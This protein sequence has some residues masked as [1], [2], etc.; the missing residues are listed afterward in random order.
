MQVWDDRSGEVLLRPAPF[1][2]PGGGRAV[3]R[4]DDVVGASLERGAGGLRVLAVGRRGAAVWPLD[5]ARLAS[6]RAPRGCPLRSAPRSSSTNS[7]GAGDREVAARAGDPRTPRRISRSGVRCDAPLQFPVRGSV[8]PPCGS[9]EPPLGRI[10][11]GWRE[12][13]ALF[14]SAFRGVLRAPRVKESVPSQD[15]GRSDGA[16]LPG[17]VRTPDGP[18]RGARSRTRRSRSPATHSPPARSPPCDSRARPAVPVSV[19]ATGESTRPARGLAIACAT[20]AAASAQA[21]PAAL[22]HRLPGADY[23]RP[24]RGGPNTA[25]PICSS[26][27]GA[28]SIQGR[29]PSRTSVTTSRATASAW[30]ISLESPA[31]ELNVLVRP[32]RAPRGRPPVPIQRLHLGRRVGFGFI[33]RTRGRDPDGVRSGLPRSRLRYVRAPAQGL[34]PFQPL[35]PV[36]VGWPTGTAVAQRRARPPSGP[37]EEPIDPNLFSAADNGDNLD[38]LDLGRRSTLWPTRST[39]PPCDSRCAT[40]P[41]SPSWT[42]RACRRR[43]RASPLVAPTS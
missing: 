30:I 17:F 22:L 34:F 26:G 3:S 9:S 40:S 10:R 18:Q 8:G 20:S 33:D 15:P 36:A 27:R 1:R 32:R 28:C 16:A 13:R 24:A 21:G 5:V 39:S 25:T 12:P 6:E 23:R 14:F 41:A 4:E 37:L 38:A 31:A 43:S 42:R 19:L 35:L 2:S 7:D 29:P 11:R